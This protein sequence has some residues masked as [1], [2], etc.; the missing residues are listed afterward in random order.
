MRRSPRR[1]EIA[2]GLAGCGAQAV[3]DRGQDEARVA[4]WCERDEHGAAV[5]VLGE[6]TGELEREACLAGA[7]GAEDGQDT[8]VALVHERDCVEELLLAAEEASR[9]DGE[10]DAA[11]RPER[12][13]LLE[14]ELEQPHRARR[15]P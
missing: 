8:G 13:E 7:A 12:R 3:A 11:R 14:A 15:S 9:R 6:Q 1:A 4:E 2:S 5:R 10:L